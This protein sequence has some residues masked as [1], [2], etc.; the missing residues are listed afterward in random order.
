MKLVQ[1]R[2]DLHYL[3]KLDNENRSRLC[4]TIIAD[5]IIIETMLNDEKLDQEEWYCYEMPIY[6]E[7]YC[8]EN[9]DKTKHFTVE[10]GYEE[11]YLTPTYITNE[12][13]ENGHN[14]FPCRTLKESIEKNRLYK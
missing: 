12:V 10:K 7:V 5:I 13:D 4:N 1:S 9:E 11:K 8:C 6:G 2:S 3:E 14:N